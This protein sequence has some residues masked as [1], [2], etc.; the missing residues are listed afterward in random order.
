VVVIV[1]VRV[2]VLDLD[3]AVVTAV[4]ADAMGTAWLM[5]LRALGE[6]RGTDLVLRAALVRAGVRL[7]LLGNCHSDE[8]D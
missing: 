6:R 7:F 1:V 5:A 2:H 8:E 4:A 3:T